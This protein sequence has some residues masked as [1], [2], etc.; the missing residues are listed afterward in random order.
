M[1]KSVEELLKGST[2]DIELRIES[3]QQMIEGMVGWLYPKILRNENRML[4]QELRRR[5]NQETNKS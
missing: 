5:L 4:Y 3:N 2:G 1:K